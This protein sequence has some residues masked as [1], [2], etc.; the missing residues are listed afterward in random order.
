MTSWR[1]SR[2]PK[3]RDQTISHLV[4]PDGPFLS[5]RDM[6]WSGRAKEREEANETLGAVAEELGRSS[7]WWVTPQMAAL[8][9][10]ASAKLPADSWRAEDRP[11][12][13]GLL[14]WDG[15]VGNYRFNPPRGRD[16]ELPISAV[17]WFPL[18][19]H[20]NAGKVVHDGT[21]VVIYGR[22]DDIA[23]Q[24]PHGYEPENAPPLVPMA[25]EMID[26]QADIIERLDANDYAGGQLFKIL[27]TTWLLMRQPDMTERYESDI[28]RDIRRSYGRARRPDP[29]VSIIELR[30]RWVPAA[31]PGATDTAGNYYSH[32]FV[33]S[34]YWR[35]Q[36]YGPGRSLTRVQW[37]P[38]Y[39]KGPD[40]APLLHTE[41]VHVWRR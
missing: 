24:I 5:R 22:R 25:V 12:P 30:R 19:N 21:G 13:I 41:R 14:V 7:L 32:R 36:H 37:I 27:V 16:I 26:D 31:D 39:V 28:D 34:G 29:T 23:D 8:A 9:V 2:L 11:A 20:D 10:S 18:Y 1:A 6:Y 40:G 33:V 35:N 17:S 15:A 4:N 38:D 3:L